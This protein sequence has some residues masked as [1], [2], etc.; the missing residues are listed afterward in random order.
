MPDRQTLEHLLHT[1]TPVAVD[2][3]SFEASNTH[4]DGFRLY[5]G[6]V[7]AQALRAAAATVSDGRRVHSQHAYFLR[8]GA[9][10]IP[11]HYEVELARDGGSFSSRRV[12]AKQNGK[13]IL[14]SSLSFHDPEDGD[15][16]F[17]DMPDVPGPEG[18]MTERERE[19]ASGS[20]YP[21]FMITTGLDLDVRLPEPVDWDNP[22]RRAPKLH[23]WMKTTAPVGDEAGLHEALLAYMSDSLLIDVCMLPEGRHFYRGT[24]TASLDHALWF[25]APFRADEW[26]L[27]VTEAERLG[28]AR[29]LARG[30]FYR[31]DGALVA[32]CMQET[33]MRNKD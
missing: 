18:L 24:Q 10:S 15:E 13:P 14:V 2:T 3:N 1:L 9:T 29:G 26:L 20:L 25:H 27:F 28:S 8:P 30:R 16:Y 21:E 19:L 23:A 5:G 4:P 12:V 17:P 22:R 31:R 7:L 32:T 11:V 6:Q 33:L